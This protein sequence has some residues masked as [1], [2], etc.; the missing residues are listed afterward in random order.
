MTRMRSWMRH[1]REQAEMDRI[2]RNAAPNVR[3]E[4]LAQLAAR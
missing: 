1:R 4:L 3:A 2:L